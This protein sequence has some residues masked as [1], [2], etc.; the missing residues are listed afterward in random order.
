MKFVLG[1]EFS[2]WQ[3][4]IKSFSD[5]LRPSQNNRT[6][7]NPLA[8]P[9]MKKAER[10]IK[11][12]QNV[13][14][15]LNKLKHKTMLYLSNDVEHKKLRSLINQLFSCTDIEI[16]DLDNTDFDRISKQ[17]DGL[18]KELIEESWKQFEDE[19]GKAKSIWKY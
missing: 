5:T 7:T 14:K 3:Q 2:F 19:R 11:P 12:V 18:T 4:D 15:V 1:L 16:A 8:K 6:G 10:L 17:I 13:A 9:N